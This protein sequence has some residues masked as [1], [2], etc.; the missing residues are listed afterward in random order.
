[1]PVSDEERRHIFGGKSNEGG[2]HFERVLQRKLPEIASLKPRVASSSANSL[3]VTPECPFTQNHST[4][5]CAQAACRRFQ[6]S[7]FFT[8][9]LADVSQ[10]LRSQPRTHLVIPLRT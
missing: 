7:T 10:P 6:R 2:Y 1:M 3:S 8:G 9:C 5:C 4:W